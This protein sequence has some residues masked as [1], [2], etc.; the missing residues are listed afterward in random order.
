MKE[1][2]RCRCCDLRIES[3]EKILREWDTSITEN[4]YFVRICKD[5]DTDIDESPYARQGVANYLGRVR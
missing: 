3:A 4:E 2:F 1:Q 5:C